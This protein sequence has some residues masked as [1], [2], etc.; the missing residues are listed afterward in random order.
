MNFRALLIVAACCGAAEATPTSPPPKVDKDSVTVTFDLAGGY[1]N[2][3][4]LRDDVDGAMTLELDVI[5]P[6]PTDKWAAS[7]FIGTY[8]SGRDEKYLFNLTIDHAGNKAHATFRLA[9]K[10]KALFNRTSTV[11]F[12]SRKKLLVTID[13]TKSTFSVSINGQLLDTAE[14][15]YDP[16]FIQLGATSGRFRATF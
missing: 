3:I 8:A 15:P 1:K 11:L 12:D 2:S 4:W 5:K 6:K 16:E 14:L 9:D 7:F 13:S 10:D